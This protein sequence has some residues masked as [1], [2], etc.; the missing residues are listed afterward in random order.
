M[1]NHGAGSEKAAE[2]GSSAALKEPRFRAILL[3]GSS[4]PAGESPRGAGGGLLKA[5]SES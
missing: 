4:G 1:Q 5:G 2:L 3:P